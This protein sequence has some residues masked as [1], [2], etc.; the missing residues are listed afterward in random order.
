MFGDCLH[1]DPYEED[2]VTYLPTVP[3][4]LNIYSSNSLFINPQNSLFN[5]FSEENGSDL[6]ISIYK[7]DGSNIIFQINK[8]NNIIKVGGYQK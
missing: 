5:Y 7:E 6:S 4:S 8:S 3:K 1:N 2:I